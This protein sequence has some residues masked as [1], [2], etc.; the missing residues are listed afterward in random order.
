MLKIRNKN[1]GIIQFIDIVYRKG[2][3]CA[4]FSNFNVTMKI[5]GKNFQKN[6]EIVTK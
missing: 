2:D 3:K 5:E 4:K 6:W 1:S